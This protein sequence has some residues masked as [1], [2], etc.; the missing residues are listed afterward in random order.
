MEQDPA[1]YIDGPNL[2]QYEN[3]SPTTQL[4]PTG[5]DGIMNMPGPGDHLGTANPPGSNL[6]E[7]AY[8]ESRFGQTRSAIMSQFTREINSQIR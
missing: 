1:D 6:R 2:Y 7:E 4:D 8:F 5:L 3:S